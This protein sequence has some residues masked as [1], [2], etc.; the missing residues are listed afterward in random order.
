MPGDLFR[1]RPPGGPGCPP[2]SPPVPP[3]ALPSRKHLCRQQDRVDDL[4]IAGAAAD[5]VA[6]GEGRLLPGGIRIRVQQT[7]WR[8][9]PCRGCRSRTERPPPRRRPRC[10]PPS[11]NRSGPPP[12]GWFFP[13]AYR[14]W[15]MQ[16][17]VGLPSM[18]T[19]QVPQAPS[20]HPSF[21]EVRR[22]S[23]RRKP[24]Q[25][26]IFSQRLPFCRLP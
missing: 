8:R 13:P 3:A 10:R 11:P 15:G 12:S 21:T 2:S 19:V 1:A 18:S 16:A 23:S 7:P 20:L 25:L 6:D 17:L 22:S 4:H 24:Q 14:V 9:S 26:L 5:V